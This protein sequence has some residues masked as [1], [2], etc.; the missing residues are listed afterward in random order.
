MKGVPI[1]VQGSPGSGIRT[2]I[3]TQ[4]QVPRNVTTQERALKMILNDLH[5][6]LC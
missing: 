6:F 1:F 4:I 2:V 5:N 3:P